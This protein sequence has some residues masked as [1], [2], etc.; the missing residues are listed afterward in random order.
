[1][2][3]IRNIKDDGCKPPLWCKSPHL[4]GNTSNPDRRLKYLYRL[5]QP[6]RQ[7]GCKQIKSKEK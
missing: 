4:T 7:A 6:T 5:P 3:L 2:P 1:M